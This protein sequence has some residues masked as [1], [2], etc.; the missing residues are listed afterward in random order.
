MTWEFGN[1]ICIK[2]FAWTGSSNIIPTMN[3]T[4]D[5]EESITYRDNSKRAKLAVNILFVICVAN[6]IAIASSYFELV[7][8][9]RIRNGEQ[10][11]DFEAASSDFRQGIIGLL[12]TGLYIVSIVLFL[13]WFRR[14]Y[15]NLHRLGY[16]DLYQSENMAVWSF[17][18]PII[19]LYR[20]FRIAKE[21]V[22]RMRHLLAKYSTGYSP[23]LNI[24]IVG[25][26]W[27]L[28]LISNYIGNIALRIAIKGES[29]ADMITTTQIY[30]ISDFFDIPAAII[31]ILLIKKISNDEKL[32]FEVIKTGSYAV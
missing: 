25:V 2:Q 20:P 24:A 17:F 26:W 30:M 13:N 12:Q 16:K 9:E 1:G 21:I 7:L 11:T 31:T 10:V 15:G 28:F 3:S 4:L 29:V 5:Q 22:Q 19:N 18:I 14:A 32:L 27:A 23:S 8:L 6:L